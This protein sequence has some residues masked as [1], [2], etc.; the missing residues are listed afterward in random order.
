MRCKCSTN[1]KL[2]PN[3]PLVGWWRGVGRRLLS[4]WGLQR[5]LKEVSAEAAL[6]TGTERVPSPCTAAA[7]TKTKYFFSSRNQRS[8]MLG[9][10]KCLVRTAEEFWE[11][12]SLSCKLLSKSAAVRGS[13]AS[14]ARGRTKGQIVLSIRLQ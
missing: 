4:L 9:F 3:W 2:A 14:G 7:T 10:R 13:S 5:K 1:W 12:S 11:C 6:W 8:E